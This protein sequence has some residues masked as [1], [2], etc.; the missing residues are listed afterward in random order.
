MHR[1]SISDT[2]RRNAE[3]LGIVLAAS[4]LQTWLLPR[5]QAADV[6]IDLSAKLYSLPT[7]AIGLHTSVYANQWKN[8]ALPGLLSASGVQM[9]R[10]PGGSY[11]DSYHWAAPSTSSGYIAAGSDFGN[12]ARV[13]SQSSTV[14]MVTV[15]YGSSIPVG[16]GTAGGQPQEAAAWV[17]YANGTATN[18][19]AIGLDGN[20]RDWKTVGFWASLRASAPL[21][22]DDGYNF[23]RINRPTPIG[24][25]HWE[26]GNEIFGNG[27]YGTNYNWETDQHSTATGSARVNNAALSPTAYGNNFKQFASAMK[28]VDSTIKVGAVLT[29][30]GATGDV[31]DPTK[32]WNR[33]VLL[34]AGSA[35]DFAS[36]HYYANNGAAPAT[37]D[38][39]LLA[40]P[41][42]EFKTILGGVQN[43]IVSYTGKA[44]DAIPMHVTEL[45]YFG[46][47]SSATVSGLYAADAYATAFDNGV[48]SAAWL[49]MSKGG[50]LTDDASLSK[51][52]I[53]Y[54]L[55]AISKLTGGGQSSGSLVNTI[56]NNSLLRSH[57]SL[58]ADGRIGLMLIND[59]L[60]H[61]VNANVALNDPGLMA[62][63][64]RYTS[65]GSSLSQT[66]LGGT[67]T[68]QFSVQL[69]A[70]TINTFILTPIPE[71][72]TLAVS[73][74]ALL[75]GLLGGRRRG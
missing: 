17:A 41:A 40:T 66:L 25:T 74:A 28:S 6:A 52:S 15:D 62:S 72:T 61:N 19:T 51:G 7:D 21:S 63:V 12:F 20:G 38:S 5:A 59:D 9:L 55:Q 14:G 68:D 30:K 60:T 73:L 34:Q 42:G 11:S 35:I 69:A 4:V 24:V 43:D 70:G 57:A 36:V 54:A 64:V 22:T 26:V 45:G 48:G 53:Y 13:L 31:I 18:T 75:P 44:R 16:G 2:Q 32:N 47:T 37:M 39:N 27:Y 65:D 71:P 10:Y 23:L 56:S 50:F 67:Y 29:Y 3:R 58:L 8:A 1:F 46:S 49:E 33:N